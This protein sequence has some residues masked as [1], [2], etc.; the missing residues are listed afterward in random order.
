M[1]EEKKEKKAPAKKA[2]TAKKTATKATA[3]KTATKT[4]AKKPATAVKKTATKAATKTAAKKTATKAATK[5]TAKKTAAKKTTTKTTTKKATTKTVAKKTTAKTTK[6]A[7]AKKTTRAKKV[8]EVVADDAKL[9][10]DLEMEDA[11]LNKEPVV[12]T[13]VEVP[14][15]STSTNEF[16]TTTISAEVSKAYVQ[17]PVEEQPFTTT[18][19]QEEKKARKGGRKV[20]ITMVIVIILAIAAFLGLWYFSKITAHNKIVDTLDKLKAGDQAT[21]VELIDLTNTLGL[22]VPTETNTENVSD[23]LIT[24]NETNTN[25]DTDTTTSLTN[26]IIQQSKKD[27]K[28]YIDF[29]KKM[30]YEIVE[31]KADFVDGYVKVKIINKN[32]G[33]IIKKYYVRAFALSI[34]TA[35]ST[36]ESS[37]VQENL[38]SYLKQLLTSDEIE[39]VSTEVTFKLK[40]EG[41]EWKLDVNKEELCDAILPGL[42]EQL[43]DF[44]F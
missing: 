30:E 5:T 4:A 28:D 2:T 33:K 14:V 20:I 43:K 15:E 26:E 31:E 24:N 44:E 6:K 32:I 25:T 13:P 10:Q 19:S 34:R 8:E 36:Q 3:K 40:R 12:E 37:Q 23:L 42:R 41:F 35:F 1:S 18:V 39:R 29:F 22:D 21:E 16:G 17:Q 11:A 27:E 38:D 7:P 9:I